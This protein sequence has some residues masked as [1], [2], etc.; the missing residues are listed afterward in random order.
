[1]KLRPLVAAVSF[2]LIAASV[3]IAQVAPP[4]GSPPETVL[5]GRPDAPTSDALD[6]AFVSTTGGISVRPP[7]GGKMQRRAGGTGDELVRFVDEKNNWSMIVSRVLLSEPVPLAS[8]QDRTKGSGFA[9][10]MA[11]QMPSDTPGKLIRS[12]LQPINGYDGALLASRFN[13]KGVGRLMQQAIV[14]RTDKSYYVITYTTA[15]TQDDLETDPAAQKAMET[16]VKIVDSITLLDQQ[17]IAD[18]QNERLIRSRAI[19]VNWT[20][21][22]LHKV[23]VPEQYLRL[24]KDGQDIGYTYIVEEQ[25]ADLPRKVK[26]GEDKSRD[27]GVRIG[28]RS[29]TVPVDGT[30]VD[31]ESWMWVQDNRKAETFHNQLVSTQRGKEKE[32]TYAMDAGM[33]IQPDRVVPVMEKRPEGAVGR[34]DPVAAFP[35]Y[36]LKVVST[37]KN[38]SLPPIDRELPPYYLPQALVHL[39]PRLLPLK[40]PRTYLFASYVPET[41]QVMTRYVDVKEG[42]NVTLGGKTKWAIPVEER[43]GLEG[44]ITTHYLTP[45][46]AYLGS[47]NQDN[48]IT[49]LATD[50]K[51]LRAIWKDAKFER[52]A[53][54]DD[55]TKK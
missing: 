1:M 49:I 27:L 30:A 35:P 23:L 22:K 37:S 53:E 25:A 14:R 36:T 5:P 51:S 33:S 15:L 3:A 16:F 41:R 29:R 38:Q 19:M 7:P 2:A 26:K 54:V 10:T 4:A 21:E 45:D 42:K 32:F 44:S 20:P 9:D 13:E 48:N 31:A 6:P 50:E 40:E 28:I 18:D 24:L 55:E 34:Q 47:I 52:P 8:P 39:L 17:N 46:G 12:D 11:A 43:A